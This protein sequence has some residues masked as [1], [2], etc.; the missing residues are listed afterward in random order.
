MWIHLFTIYAEYLTLNIIPD[1]PSVIRILSSTEPKTFASQ[2]G[3][4]RFP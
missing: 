4:M 2:N 1:L 3:C